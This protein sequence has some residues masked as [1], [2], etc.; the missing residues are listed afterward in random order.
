VQDLLDTT[1]RARPGRDPVVRDE[2]TQVLETPG[3][4][5]GVSRSGVS[6][7]PLRCSPEMLRRLG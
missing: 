3:R 1:L 2:D 7:A 6:R 5:P 4:R